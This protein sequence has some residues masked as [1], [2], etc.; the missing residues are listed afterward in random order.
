MRSLGLH[1][2]SLKNL[3]DTHYSDILGTDLPSVLERLCP[4]FRS[5]EESLHDPQGE[6]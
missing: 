3:Q 4:A 6:G 5:W 1:L 2:L